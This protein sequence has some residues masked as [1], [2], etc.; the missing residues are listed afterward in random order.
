MNIV[1]EVKQLIYKYYSNPILCYKT[2]IKPGA[3]RMDFETFKNVVSDMYKKEQR[4]QMNYTQ[5]KSAYD[6]VDLRKDGMIDLNEWTKAFG[7]VNGS[8][9]VNDVG[10]MN[11]NSFFNNS[12]NNSNSVNSGNCTVEEKQRKQL[13]EWE[14]SDDVC[15]IY[16]IIWKHKKYI[17]D[18]LRKMF[19]NGRKETLVLPENLI[20]VL[21]EIMPRMKLS[22]TQWKILVNIGKCEFNEL[23]DIDMFFTMVEIAAKSAVFK[24]RKQFK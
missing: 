18:S 16:K 7:D 14:T 12:N 17:R 15:E 20:K 5:I 19:F 3:L 4:Q 13:R 22:Y 1:G 8:L 24:P 9:D 21:K 23:I 6:V 10:V 2:C 11:G